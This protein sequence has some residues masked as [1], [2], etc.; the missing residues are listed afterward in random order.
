MDPNYEYTFCLKK[1]YYE[2]TPIYIYHEKNYEYLL[3]K[4]DIQ[5]SNKKNIYTGLI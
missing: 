4:W 2:Y 5:L 1:Y 3:R